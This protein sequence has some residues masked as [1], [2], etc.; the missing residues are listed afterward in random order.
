MTYYDY[1]CVKAEVVQNVSNTYERS[2]KGNLVDLKDT[3]SPQKEAKS[4]TPQV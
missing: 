4:S 3:G 1:G 2:V